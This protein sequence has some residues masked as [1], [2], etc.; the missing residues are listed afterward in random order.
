MKW[1]LCFYGTY[2]TSN[3]KYEC[4][5]EASTGCFYYQ[6]RIVYNLVFSIIFLCIYLAFCSS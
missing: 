1:A 5:I 3:K 2:C 4:L 6:V